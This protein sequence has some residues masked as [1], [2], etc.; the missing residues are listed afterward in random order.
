LIDGPLNTLIPFDA[1]N[2]V[3][4]QVVDHFSF[5]FSAA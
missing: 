1:V 2:L 5:D 4:F 3:M